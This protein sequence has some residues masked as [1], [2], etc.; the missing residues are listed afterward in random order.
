MPGVDDG[1]ET[2]T[3]SEEVTKKEFDDGAVG[4]AFSSHFYLDNENVDEF[5]A[6]RDEALER[7]NPSY[8][9]EVWAEVRMH[10]DLVNFDLD[11]LTL[12][13]K[14]ILLEYPYGTIKPIWDDY[15]IDEMLKRNYTPVLAHVERFPYL[16]EADL[17]KYKSKGCLL[18]V[19]AD[20]ATY[21]HSFR[22]MYK[23]GLVDVVAS[24]THGWRRPPKLKEAYMAIIENNGYDVAEELMKNSKKL[25]FG[26]IEEV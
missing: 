26:N 14:Y 7:L 1:V 11:R 12:H 10:P 4:I 23:R 25:F 15:V 2:V 13:H 18:Q 24:D 8:P 17:K 6:R 9:H 22:K 19:N 3:E 5:L 21:K 20:F 16:S